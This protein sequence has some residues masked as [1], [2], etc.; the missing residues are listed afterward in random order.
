MR[1]DP[2]DPR[3]VQVEGE[4]DAWRVYFHRRLPDAPGSSYVRDE[5]RLRDAPDAR[6]V[7]A[8]AEDH[9]DGRDYVVYVEVRT[10]QGLTLIRV[11]GDEP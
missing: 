1:A 2:V 10:P 9:A 7:L 6:A 11:Q 5:Y 4:A 8:W 3:D